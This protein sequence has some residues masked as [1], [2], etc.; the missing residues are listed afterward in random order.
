MATD[1]NLEQLED[2][3]GCFL[4]MPKEKYDE[5]LAKKKELLIKKN[6]ARISA[7]L[8]KK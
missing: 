1:E 7:K 6:T 2:E 8:K 4:A 3:A 5:F